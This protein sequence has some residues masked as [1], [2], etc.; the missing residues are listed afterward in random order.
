MWF[1]ID[2]PHIP[3]IKVEMKEI[4]SEIKITHNIPQSITL[5]TMDLPSKIMLDSSMLPTT[6]TLDIPKEFPTII[7]LDTSGI[8]DVIQVAGIPSVIELL[9]TIPSQIQMVMPE[10]PEIEL[11]YKGAPIDM[12]IHLDTS[13][14][15]GED[16]DGQCFRLVPCVAK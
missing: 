4:P 8:P 11:V 14:L 1:K 3:P 2:T 12:K 13:K 10:K 5:V 7:M 6:I 16:G 15:T 9:G